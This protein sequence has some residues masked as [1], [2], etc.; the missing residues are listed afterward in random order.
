MKTPLY[1]PPSLFQILSNPPSLSNP[2]P[3]PTTHFV[4][5]FLW[6]NGWSR[7]IWCAILLDDV[8]DIHMSSLRTL[9]HVLCSKATNLLNSDKWCGF[10]L[11]LSFDLSQTHLHTHTYKNTHRE[12]HTTQRSVDWH[13]HINTY[14]HQLL[15]AHSSYLYYIEWI[16]H[17]YQ[18]FTFHNVSSFQMLIRLGSFCET[19]TILIK[20]V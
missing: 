12:R 2:N 18:K 6:L 19:Q 14:L 7:H 16:I 13:T 20:M 15:C 5:F 8:M 9:V 17:W 4:F 11:V 3:T 10:L 1:C